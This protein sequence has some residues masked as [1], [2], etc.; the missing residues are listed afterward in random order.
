MMAAAVVATVFVVGAAALVVV[1]R[2]TQDRA[3]HIEEITRPP[4]DADAARRAAMGRPV[5]AAPAPLPTGAL[6]VFCRRQIPFG[7]KHDCA[8]REVS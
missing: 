8:M 4:F 2:R 1:A 3:R 5:P 7:E 6:C